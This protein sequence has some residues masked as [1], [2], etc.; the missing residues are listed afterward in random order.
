M[1]FFLAEKLD[2]TL[3]K[4]SSSPEKKFYKDENDDVKL[5]TEEVLHKLDRYESNK[6]VEVFLQE[7]IDLY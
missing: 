6:E 7:I 5:Q 3:S 4:R 2:L 1:S